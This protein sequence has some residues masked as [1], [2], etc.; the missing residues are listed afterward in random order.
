[1]ASLSDTANGQLPL[2]R[3]GCLFVL[4]G[5]YRQVSITNARQRKFCD[6]YVISGNAAQ[7]AIAAGYSEK[8]AKSIG[9]RLLTFVDLRAYI[10]ERLEALHNEKTADAQEVLEYLTSVM[11]GENESETVVVIGTGDGCSEA[12]TV[13]KR[14]DEKERLKAAELLGKRHGLF[15]D[16]LDISGTLPVVIMGGEDLDD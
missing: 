12:V 4:R 1:M 6:E 7:A 13:K 14:P 8:T 3:R 9:Q 10:D 15:S 16:K 11:R 5:H 2:L